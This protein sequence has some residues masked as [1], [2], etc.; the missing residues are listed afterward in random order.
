VNSQKFQE[1]DA[2]MWLYVN[3]KR[4][5]KAEAPTHQ[6]HNF[7]AFQGCGDG[8]QGRGIRGRGGRGGSD[9][10][11]NRIVPQEEVDKVTTVEAK[12]YPHSEYSKFTPAKKQKHYQLIK[13]TNR[14]G[15]SSATVAELTSTVSAVSAAALAISELTAKSNKH[16][17]EDGKTNDDEATA[18]SEWGRNRNNPAVAGRKERELKKPKS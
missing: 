12:W 15:K 4:T 18:N 1:F 10:R 6:A 11:L 8:R 13:K 3:C 7:S 17:A 2:V 9:A 5:Q 14:T 16:A